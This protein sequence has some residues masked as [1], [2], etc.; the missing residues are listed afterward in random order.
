MARRI[1]SSQLQ[2]KVRQAVQKQRQAINKYNQA[3]NRYNQAV[4]TYSS[5]VNA[6]RRRIKSELNKL[7]RHPTTI[8]ST[9][10]RYAVLRTS[11]TTMHEAY[12]LLEQRTDIQH[13]GPNHEQVLDLSERETANSLEVMNSL[14][15][16]QHPD[17]ES[18]DLQTLRLT[19][20]LRKISTDLD[21]RWQGAVFSLNPHNPDATR[22]FCTSAR[23]VFTQILE[24]KAPDAEVINTLP[25]CA[26]TDEGKPTRRAKI[27]YFLHQRGMTDGALEEFVEQD[28]E[29]IVQLFRVL[30]DG[31]H[32]SAGK[33]D[34][35]Q[36]SSIKKR[37]E[38]GI[39]FLSELVD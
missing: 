10:T 5:R 33:F 6:Q 16:T 29:N 20:E 28:M 7:G 22:H 17:E 14:L 12:A 36:L 19:D 27:K 34:R 23:E 30:N 8:R 11:V 2:S 32:G 31:T 15:G 9:T 18:D 39:L 37:V 3:A 24:I 13:L 26:T 4:R 35:S 1:S 38:D 25:G 21:D